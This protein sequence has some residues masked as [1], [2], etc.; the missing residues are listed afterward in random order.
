MTLDKAIK[1]KK[2]M[3]NLGLAPYDED[4]FEADRLSIE[5]IEAV[6]RARRGDFAFLLDGLPGE[7]KD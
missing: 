5:A 1:I 2:E 4:T 6:K 3:H 7:T